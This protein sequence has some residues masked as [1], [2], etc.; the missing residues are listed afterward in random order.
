MSETKQSHGML[1]RCPT[2]HAQMKVWQHRLTPGLV[3]LLIKFVAGVRASG[4]NDVHIQKELDLTRS[5]DANFQKLRYFGL[6]AKVMVG[7]V[8]Q[9]GHW[10]ITR[11]GGQF[12]RGMEGVPVWV[13]TWRNHIEE[14]SNDLVTISKFFKDPFIEGNREYFQQDFPFEVKEVQE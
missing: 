8:H 3:K 14:R 4:K 13:K 9:K 6:V 12:L 5:E 11:R 2:C 1:K 7:G 10:L